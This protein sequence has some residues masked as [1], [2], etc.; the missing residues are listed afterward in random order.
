MAAEPVSTF[1]TWAAARFPAVCFPE[2]EDNEFRKMIVNLHSSAPGRFVF[3][4]T[5]VTSHGVVQL[6]LGG[7]TSAVQGLLNKHGVVTEGFDLDHA[8][9]LFNLVWFGF[10][11]L[12]VTTHSDGTL[13]VATVMDL[14]DTEIDT[15]LCTSAAKIGLDTDGLLSAFTL[16]DIRARYTQLRRVTQPN[17]VPAVS[18]LLLLIKILTREFD[19]RT[20]LVVERVAARHGV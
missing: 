6:N 14:F 18:K 8:R 5:T 7:S 13:V 10:Q 20:V 3:P 16:D 11:A 15:K 1:E 4:V 12:R 17:D 19:S 2:H 9:A